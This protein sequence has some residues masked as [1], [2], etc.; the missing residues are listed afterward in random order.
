MA[1]IRP[2][3]S[4]VALAIVGLAAPAGASNPTTHRD[5]SFHRYEGLG[6]LT[7]SAAGT[8]RLGA[9]RIARPLRTTDY[10]DPFGFGTRKYDYAQWT[11]PEFHPGFGL[12]ELVSSWNAETP[13]GTWIQ[14]QM[15]GKTNNGAETKWYVM[16]R[17]ASD[18]AD[19]HR[20]SVSQQGDDDGYVATDTFFSNDGISLRDYQLRVTLYRLAGTHK[21]PVVREIGAVA[22]A[23][24]ADT[25]VP[26]SPLGGAE[27]IELKVPSYAQNLHIGQYTNYGGGGEAWCSAT[28]TAMVADY[29]GA[30]PSQQDLAKIDPSYVDP[31]VDVAAIGT[32]DYDYDGTGNWPFNVAYAAHYGLSGEVTQLRSLNEAEQ[33]IKAGI[34]LITSVSFKSSELDGA[35]YSTDGHLMVIV[36]FTKTG[37]VITRDPASNSDAG[38][39]NVYKRGQFENVWLPATRSD[40][41]VYVIHPSRMPLPRSESGLPHNW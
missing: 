15:R 1:R 8:S 2:L 21:T 40:G 14:V 32:Y 23:L 7:G 9:L 19:F 31:D 25:S 39:R 12:T 27:G 33:F 13:D 26:T 22:S 34:P 28:S 18:D 10:T 3:L 11:S 16:G 20:T 35:G 5:I 30:Y 6:F 36:G 41:I 24:P 29:F 37:D 4:V 17:W 38:V